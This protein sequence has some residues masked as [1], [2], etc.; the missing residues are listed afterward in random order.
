MLEYNQGL[1][2]ITNMQLTVACI[3]SRSWNG[4]ANMHAWSDKILHLFYESEGET[5]GK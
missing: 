1:E 2:S 4:M 3:L 5:L